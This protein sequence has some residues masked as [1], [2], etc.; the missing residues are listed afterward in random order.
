MS[1]LTINRFDVSQDLKTDE[2]NEF[3]KNRLEKALED[4]FEKDMREYQKQAEEF[5]DN[6][7]FK[8]L[9]SIKSKTITEITEDDLI[10][11]GFERISDDNY[12]II[13]NYR[14]FDNIKFI[15]T[16]YLIDLN[17]L[18]TFLRKRRIFIQ[19]K[20]YLIIHF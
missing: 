12:D 11:I 17:Y 9:E 4:S 16:D 15:S 13:Y 8:R 19:F 3:E 10:Y 14:N 20:S 2:M 18:D 6:L 7:D 5:I 1:D